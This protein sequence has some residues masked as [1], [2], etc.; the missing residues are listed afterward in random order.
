MAVADVYNMEGKKFKKVD[1]DDNVFNV[2]VKPHVLHEVVVMQL[3]NRRSGSAATKGRS[4]VRGGGQKPYRQKGT[5]RARAGSRSSP[6]WRGGGV[7]WFMAMFLGL[8]EV[9]T[10]P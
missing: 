3:A 1:L 6:L 2:A 4:D 5:G 7:V 8:R 9:W 10:F